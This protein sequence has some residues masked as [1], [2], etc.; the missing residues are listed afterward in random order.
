MRRRA[1]KPQIIYGEPHETMGTACAGQA[2]RGGGERRRI[3]RGVAEKRTFWMKID[4]G[5]G[6]LEMPSA[7]T[8]PAGILPEMEKIQKW[9]HFRIWSTFDFWPNKVCG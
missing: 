7:L 5:G 6:S 3:A 1:K 4:R 2:G 8:D 9:I